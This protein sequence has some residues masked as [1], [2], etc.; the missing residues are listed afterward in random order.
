MPIR[1]GVGCVFF[2][3]C[4]SC[5]A[6]HYS[7][8][9]PKYTR[10]LNEEVKLAVRQL[11]PYGIMLSALHGDETTHFELL[12][13]PPNTPSAGLHV[14]L[15]KQPHYVVDAVPRLY[16]GLGLAGRIQ[17][18]TPVVKGVPNA[19]FDRHTIVDAVWQVIA[20]LARQTKRS[21]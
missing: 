6:R 2:I 7:D 5:A 15:S 17:T 8:T 1:V 20:Q 16:P 9:P 13:V 18:E 4:V 14:P 21:V 19:P 12:F 3:R 11:L 10:R